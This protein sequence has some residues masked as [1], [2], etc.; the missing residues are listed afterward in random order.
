MRQGTRRAAPRGQYPGPPPREPAKGAASELRP[1]RSRRSPKGP[2][3][4][5]SRSL[6]VTL[7]ERGHGKPAAL[8]IPVP[9]KPRRRCMTPQEIAALHKSVSPERWPRRSRGAPRSA[10]DILAY[11]RAL[12][13]D[14][15]VVAIGPKAALAIVAVATQ[16]RLRAADAS[17]GDHRSPCGCP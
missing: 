7:D 13:A 11:V 15:E 3:P 6:R 14:A 5:S 2:I 17:R 8:L 16:S 10:V 9:D 4:R 12:L 1:S